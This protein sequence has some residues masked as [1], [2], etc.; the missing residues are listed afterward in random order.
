MLALVSQGGVDTVAVGA[1]V[2]ESGTLLL[3]GSGLFGP[4]GFA[5]RRRKS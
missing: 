5:W 4:G 2:P 1:P 3:L